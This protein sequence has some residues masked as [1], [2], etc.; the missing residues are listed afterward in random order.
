[1][2]ATLDTTMHRS[3]VRGS[4][5]AWQQLE[6]ARLVLMATWRSAYVDHDV[7]LSICEDIAAEQD[8]LISLRP[9]PEGG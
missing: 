4:V 1:M 8:R 3:H 9:A 2:A 7:V 6:K 5:E